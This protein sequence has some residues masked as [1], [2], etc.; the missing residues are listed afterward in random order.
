MIGI[1]RT[2]VQ[3]I[4]LITR[5]KAH[6]TK[7]VTAV[8]VGGGVVAIMEVHLGPEETII[9][10][11]TTIVTTAATTAVTTIAVEKEGTEI[12]IVTEIE[13]VNGT[14]VEIEIVVEIEIGIVI[15]DVIETE[16]ET[17]IGIEIEIEVEIGTE[18][19]IVTGI[20]TGIEIGTGIETIT[21]E[22]SPIQVLG[23]MNHQTILLCYG[24]YPFTSPKTM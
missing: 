3:I 21:L 17:V 14:G 8:E 6:L 2:V 11:T 16:A 23:R 20:E 9:A 24:D 5:L 12:E 10:W 18:I 19:E 7:T 22:E 13:V 4:T 15:E 1:M